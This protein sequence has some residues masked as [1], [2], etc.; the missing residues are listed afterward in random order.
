[1]LA[2]QVGQARGERG[3]PPLPAYLQVA[4]WT[5]K[6]PDRHREQHDG[7]GSSGTAGD[8]GEEG[9]E[10]LNSGVRDADGGVERGEQ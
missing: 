8:R 2:L 4:E 7:D 9:G 3:T 10:A 6:Q 5:D 1:V